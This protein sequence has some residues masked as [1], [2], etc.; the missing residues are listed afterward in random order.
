MEGWLYLQTTGPYAGSAPSESYGVFAAR[1]EE[2]IRSDVDVYLTE[3]AIE[4]KKQEG[5]PAA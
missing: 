5:S 2:L 4:R 3:V 1:V